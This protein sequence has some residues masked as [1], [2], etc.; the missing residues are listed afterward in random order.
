MQTKEEKEEKK[1]G[2]EGNKTVVLD[3]ATQKWWH[4]R[5]SYRIQTEECSQKYL[6]KWLTYF[7]LFKKNLKI[8]MYSI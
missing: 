1:E 7:C 8:Q 5:H 3:S 4:L 6:R 2:R